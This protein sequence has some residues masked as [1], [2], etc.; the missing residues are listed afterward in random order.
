MKK[1]KKKKKKKMKKMKKKRKKPDVLIVFQL[2]NAFFCCSPYY[3]ACVVSVRSGAT[4]NCSI[5]TRRLVSS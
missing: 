4:K 3:E 5:Q 1:K 2:G